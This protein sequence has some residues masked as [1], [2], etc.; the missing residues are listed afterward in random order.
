[1]DL[2]LTCSQRIVKCNLLMAGPADLQWT[3]VST[4]VCWKSR[5][6]YEAALV[7][8]GEV[9]AWGRAMKAPPGAPQYN[10]SAGGVLLLALF[11]F[12]REKY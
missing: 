8:C 10:G 11:V 12:V 7:M 2:I 1:M 4:F 3:K 5:V 9:R 6:L